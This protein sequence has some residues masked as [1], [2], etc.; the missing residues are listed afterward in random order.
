[1]DNLNKFTVLCQINGGCMGC[2]GHNYISKEMIREAIKFNT[3]EFSDFKHND[4]G[5]LA[6]RDR[7]YKRDLRYGV[8]RN[9]IEKNG[10]VLCPLHP[11]VCGKELR[12]DHCDIYYLCDTARKFAKWSEEKR[13]K[14]LDFV[15][16]K[17]L[18]SIEYSMKMD[19]NSLLKEFQESL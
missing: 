13:V 19:D 17:N 6:F 4:E 15:K 12:Q 5:L 8:C 9:L 11:A 3:I 18:D 10:Q 2:C 7:A 1:M 14:F 16:S